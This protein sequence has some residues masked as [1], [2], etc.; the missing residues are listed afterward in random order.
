MVTQYTDE[1]L[2]PGNW[3]YFFIVLSFCSALFAMLAYIFSLRK[4]DENEKRQWQKI[5]NIAFLTGGVAVVAIFSILFYLIQTHQFQYYYVWAHSSRSLSLKYMISC[6]WEG[7]EGS[8]LLWT[9]WHYVLGAIVIFTNKK[10]TPGVLLTIAGAQA[11]LM[12]MLLGIE[13]INLP[14][15]EISL[16]TA[17]IGSNPFS[18]LRHA[19]PDIPV[20][21]N[22]GYMESVRNGQLDGR[23]LNVLLQNYWMV[24]HPPVLFLGFASTIV[25]F[26][27]AMAGLWT[28]RFSEWVK[29]ALSWTAF[30][31]GALGL[32]ILMGGAW[33]YEAL[34]FG[35]F[36]AWDPVENASLVPWL[37]M[38][39]GL[40][41]MIIFRARK[42]AL[43]I[44]YILISL[45]FLLILYSTFLTRSGVLADTSVHSFTDL[46][47]S[48]QLLIFMVGFIVLAIISIA[49]YWKAIPKTEKEEKTYSREFWMFIGALVL[50]MSAL[51]IIAITSIPV[52]NKIFSG[53]NSLI[54]TSL[55]TK[56]SKP[57]DVIAVYHQLQIPLAVIV[58][59]G[60]GFSQYLRY[61]TTPPRRFWK[62][63]LV[64]F[65]VSV[66]IGAGFALLVH[67]TD[68][69]YIAL[70]V[71]ATFT[72]ISNGE[73]L[74]K[75]I[76]DKQIRLSGSAVA[77]VGFGL[78]LIGALVSNA[79][80][81]A[82]SINTENYDALKEASSKEKRENKV[83]FKNQPV[84]MADYRVTYRGD[85]T[86][87]DHIYYLVDYVKFDK[88]FKEEK[89][90]FTLAPYVSFDK[91][92][93]KFT[94]ASPSTRHYLTRDVF[95]H[96]SSASRKDDE[97]YKPKYDKQKPITLHIEEKQIIDSIPVELIDVRKEKSEVNG[98]E[99]YRLVAKI[100]VTDGTIAYFAEPT[101]V[102]DG[103]DVSSEPAEIRDIAVQFYYTG[104][105]LSKGMD[106]NEGHNFTMVSGKRPMMPFI[107]MKAI[108]FP[109]INI[110]WLGCITMVVGCFIAARRR[111]LDSKSAR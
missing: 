51:H 82:I 69:L 32:G 99:V 40:H 1:N 97:D 104:I 43:A 7:Q 28:K 67:L 96:I 3:G 35:G 9:L 36:W 90:K 24:I 57:E 53:I 23:G 11:M 18:L 30:G 29:P 59:I 105:D 81:E 88:D 15:A 72:V 48:G 20:F 108:V 2:A 27:F 60:M 68:P 102:I 101:L 91:K 54:G 87:G 100:R 106:G 46:G 56:M 111:Y 75:T 19:F 71:A 49:R 34:S 42:S 10:W 73:I 4:K 55:P 64:A 76:R 85:S 16:G 31:V 21:A 38:V 92:E 103:K 26:G 41:T 47:L 61:I 86:D 17:K 14:G 52:I 109:Y 74:L 78:L 45:A 6:F 58:A 37:I 89:E 50:C 95:T 93:D 8:F 79:K 12:S 110:L 13:H 98:R 65:G 22:A 25:P 62:Q 5:G 94:S 80:K 44:S 84:K 107:T 70:L 77:H 39:A 83:L 33:A 63:N 66:L